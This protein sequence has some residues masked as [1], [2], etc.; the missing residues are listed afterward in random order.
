MVVVD[1]AD[2]V[3]HQARVRQH[4][5]DQVVDLVDQVAAVAHQATVDIA[6]AVVHQD[7]QVAVQSIWAVVAVDKC[8]KNFFHKRSKFGR[9]SFYYQ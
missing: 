5:Q 2:Q 1:Q 6:E 4:H 7:P 9:F 8:Q 3:A